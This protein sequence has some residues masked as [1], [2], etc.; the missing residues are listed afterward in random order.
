[1]GP[2]G[3]AWRTSISVY[4]TK[5]WGGGQGQP[6]AEQ[7]LSISISLMVFFRA[8][9]SPWVDKTLGEK[10]FSRWKTP[11]RREMHPKIQ[12]SRA[13]ILGKTFFKRAA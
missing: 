13:G 5:R 3:G 9:P 12:A 2:R 1:M 10:L 11:K 6:K 8:D 4:Y 7:G